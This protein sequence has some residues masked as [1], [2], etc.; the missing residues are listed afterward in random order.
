MEQS[1]KKGP[2]NESHFTSYQHLRIHRSG[3]DPCDRRARD[4]DRSHAEVG[5]MRF[6][7][8]NCHF[9]EWVPEKKCVLCQLEG[10]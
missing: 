9:C 8:L 2:A 3:L 10:K 1:H 6:R 4:G 5:G 7:L